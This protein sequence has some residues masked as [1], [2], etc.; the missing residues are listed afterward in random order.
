M[1]FGVSSPRAF[2]NVSLGRS[3]TGDPL[4]LAISL[5]IVAFFVTSYRCISRYTKRLWWHDD[6]VALFSMLCYVFFVIGQ[7]TPFVP[8][9]LRAKTFGL[10]TSLL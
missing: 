2:H 7:C 9:P 4:D 6:S 3:L 1:T 8:D 5:F 10:T